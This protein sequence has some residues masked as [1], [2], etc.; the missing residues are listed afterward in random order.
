MQLWHCGRSSHSL[1][2]NGE[3]PVSASAIAIDAPAQVYTPQGM[4]P[5]ETPRALTI[6]EIK[7]IRTGPAH[8]AGFFPGPEMLSVDFEQRIDIGKPWNVTQHMLGI[9]EN[10]RCDNRERRIFAARDWH[11]A[12]QAIST[13]N[14]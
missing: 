13:F 5:F 7:K 14:N 2:L 4:K 1:L 8:L 3:L 11:F 6:D 12:K 9:C 10:S